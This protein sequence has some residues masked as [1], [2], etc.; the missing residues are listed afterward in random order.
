M[1]DAAQGPSTVRAAE[2]AIGN[3][4]QVRSGS[5]LHGM[6]IEPEIATKPPT[7]LAWMIEEFQEARRKRQEKLSV[8]PNAA[9]VEAVPPEPPAPGSRSE[10]VAVRP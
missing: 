10:A 8:A 6:T 1:F 5:T 9:P 7:R 4:R 2:C 3:S